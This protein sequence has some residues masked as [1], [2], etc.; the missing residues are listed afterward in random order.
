MTIGFVFAPLEKRIIGEPFPQ[1]IEVA[2][3]SKAGGQC[4][5]VV[6]QMALE[7]GEAADLRLPAGEIRFPRVV[8]GVQA[9]QIPGISRFDLVAR[10]ERF[11][12]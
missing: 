12:F 6:A 1:T 10:R 11:N 4:L 2:V 5:R 8:V 9:F 3:E 7:P